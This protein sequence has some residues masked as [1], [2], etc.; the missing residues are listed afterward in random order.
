[1]FTDTYYQTNQHRGVSHDSEGVSHD[2]VD[3]TNH[4]EL[5]EE[6][7]ET[8]KD[9]DLIKDPETD[10]DAVIDDPRDINEQDDDNDDNE[11][12]RLSPSDGAKVGAIMKLGPPLKSVH[13]E[14]QTEIVDAFK[15]A[16]KEYKASAWGMDEVKP[17]SHSS[18]TWFNLGLTI[19]D[20]LDTIWLMGLDQE[21]NEARMWVEHVF[22]LA[23]NKDVNVFE[24]TIRV[25]G[26]LLSAYHLTQDNL[27]LD[28]AVSCCCCCCYCYCCCCC[29]FLDR[30]W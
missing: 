19:I 22:N 17:I 15:Y 25:L 16:W 2:P 24:V 30:S 7:Q 27:F 14:K 18:S 13:S 4:K 11:E 21:F 20:S 12:R 29:S 1:M 26:G 3:T 10:K 9:G 28:K 5:Q 23:P 6:S 8:V